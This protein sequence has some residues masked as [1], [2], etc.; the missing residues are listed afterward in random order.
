MA[1]S[2]IDKLMEQ[3]N[4]ASV[5]GDVDKVVEIS[6]AIKKAKAEADKANA[7][8]YAAAK[9]E[10]ADWLAAG[11]ANLVNEAAGKFDIGCSIKQLKFTAAGFMGSDG[12]EQTNDSVAINPKRGGGSGSTGNGGG[13][14]RG[15]VMGTGL[16]MQQI[17]D[18][19][20]TAEEQA[21]YAA[22]DDKNARYSLVRKIV[23]RI[24][25]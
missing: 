16:T 3:L 19:H 9:A 20:G 14:Q 5:A 11:I 23:K 2:A 12:V 4:A 18:E 17:V 6:T 10:C 24:N 7:E 13:G 21:S 1:K 8:Q 25:S 22:T 15:N